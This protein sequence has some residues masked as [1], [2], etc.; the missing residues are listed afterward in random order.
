MALSNLYRHMATYASNG[1][2]A[3]DVVLGVAAE[4]RRPEAA[5]LQSPVALARAV[6]LPL[7]VGGQGED[8]LAIGLG[9]VE[10]VDELEEHLVE[11]LLGGHRQGR[12]HRLKRECTRLLHHAVRDFWRLVILNTN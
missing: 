11:L 12:G 5:V 2:D 3:V 4:V 8:G 7:L 9:K 6:D 10:L 1:L